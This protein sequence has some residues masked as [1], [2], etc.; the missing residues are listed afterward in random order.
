MELSAES[1]VDNPREIPTYIH[2]ALWF[3]QLLDFL[4]E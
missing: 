4:P 3:G 2:I 1:I